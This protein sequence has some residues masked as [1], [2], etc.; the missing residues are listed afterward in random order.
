[1]LAAAEIGGGSDGGDRPVVGDLD[2]P[3]PDRRALDRN[4]PVRR[5]D[6]HA[7]DVPAAEDIELGV[8]PGSRPLRQR[9]SITFAIQ[10]DASKRI[11]SGIV[12]NSSETGS[13][14]GS[15]IANTI[16]RT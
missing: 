16:M 4:D 8:D 11:R 13:T 7:R 3:I 12:S 14:V 1:M 10:I 5:D 6:L 15:R 2:R 9:G